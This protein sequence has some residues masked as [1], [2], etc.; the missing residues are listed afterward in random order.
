M[1]LN[2]VLLAE[3]D[4]IESAQSTTVTNLLST[5]ANSSHHYNKP[6]WKITQIA[7]IE[8]WNNMMLGPVSWISDSTSTCNQLLN[9]Y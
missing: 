2:D 7:I 8:N 5:K 3:N 9:I 4:P 1:N 6:N